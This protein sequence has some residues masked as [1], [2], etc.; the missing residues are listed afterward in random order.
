[1]IAHAFHF[2]PVAHFA[3]SCCSGCGVAR[4]Q[5]QQ[6]HFREQVG[7]QI[8]QVSEGEFRPIAEKQKRTDVVAGRGEIEV[9]S[10][11]NETKVA[12]TPRQ[13]VFERGF[14]ELIVH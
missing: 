7:A 11:M 12:R 13:R 3:T 10:N 4:R 5:Y 14:R 1:M 6:V 9:G 8:L 2:C